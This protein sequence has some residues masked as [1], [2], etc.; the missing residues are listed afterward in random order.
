MK[1][2]F[3]FSVVLTLLIPSPFLYADRNETNKSGQS[4]YLRKDRLFEDRTNIYNENGRQK[5]YLKPDNLFKDRVN[6][7]NY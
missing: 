7:Y 5:G 1:L 2:I 4:G 3:Y 6:I